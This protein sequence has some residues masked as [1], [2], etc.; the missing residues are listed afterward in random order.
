[1]KATEE[2]RPFWDPK[3]K[4]FTKSQATL[5]GRVMLGCL[6]AVAAVTNATGY[7]WAADIHGPQGWKPDV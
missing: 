1:M 4:P 2:N 5:E 6:S 7:G 3:Q